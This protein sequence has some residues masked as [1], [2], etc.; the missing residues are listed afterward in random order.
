MLNANRIKRVGI[1]AIIVVGLYVSNMGGNLYYAAV[2]RAEI[3]ENKNELDSVSMEW[4]AL[5]GR[6]KARPVS[7]DDVQSA[8]EL[9]VRENGLHRKIHN[10]ENEV[11]DAERRAF[12]PFYGV[13]E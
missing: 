3:G 1:G 12:N 4:A 5:T 8:S 6:I 11:D 7:V 13:F 9:A 10:L 2:K